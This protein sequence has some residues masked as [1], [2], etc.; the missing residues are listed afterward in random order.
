[1]KADMTLLE[2]R[3]VQKT[4]VGLQ[5]RLSHCVE[6]IKNVKSQTISKRLSFNPIL[7]IKLC[8]FG[9]LMQKT[10]QRLSRLATMTPMQLG[11]NSI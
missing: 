4:I 8:R 3:R 9:K 7:N 10:L 11:Q 1:M 6:K 2:N 5:D